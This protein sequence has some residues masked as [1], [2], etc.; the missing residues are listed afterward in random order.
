VLGLRLPRSDRR[1]R[2]SFVFPTVPGALPLRTLGIPDVNGN[3]LANIQDRV[4]VGAN[5]EV[6]G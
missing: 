5:Y 2:A 4:L 6:T 1:R 3:G